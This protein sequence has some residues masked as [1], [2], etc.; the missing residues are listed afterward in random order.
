M[1]ESVTQQTDVSEEDLF[2]VVKLFVGL[3]NDKA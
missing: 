1:R 2:K 3:N